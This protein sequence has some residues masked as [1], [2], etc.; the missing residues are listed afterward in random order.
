MQEILLHSLKHNSSLDVE[1]L[2][3]KMYIDNK[4]IEETRVQINNK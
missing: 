3:E 1:E 2:L 4:M